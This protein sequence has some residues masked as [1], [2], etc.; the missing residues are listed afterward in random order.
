MNPNVTPEFV[1]KHSDKPWYWGQF[2]LSSN[3]FK[4]CDM[5]KQKQDKAARIIQNG[6]LY[7]KTVQ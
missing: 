7:A 3:T 4:M 6:N 1:E 2:G 5:L